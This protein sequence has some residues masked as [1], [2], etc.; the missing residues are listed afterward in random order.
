MPDMNKTAGAGKETTVGEVD[1]TGKTS[2]AGKAAGGLSGRFRKCVCLC[3]ALGMALAMGAC[4]YGVPQIEYEKLVS[5]NQALQSRVEELESRLSQPASSKPEAS[6][7][8]SREEPS[9]SEPAQS[10]RPA[11][12]DA[13][14]VQSQLK[15]TE[16]TWEKSGYY[17]VAFAVKNESGYEINLSA[18]LLLYDGEDS[19]IG[20][21]DLEEYAIPVGGE[22]L[23]TFSND[24]KFDHYTYE[25][26]PSECGNFYCV[27][28]DLEVTVN[29]AKGK[30]VVTV[31]NN[32]ELPAEFC[33]CTALF[34]SGGKPVGSYFTFCVDDDNE[35]KPGKSKS[36][37][38]RSYGSYDE[39]KVFVT[40]Q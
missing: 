10:A 29:K 1:K 32:G 21:K 39:V 31:K 2:K 15:V 4:S 11:A 16:Y 23:F 24:E 36:S 38:I 8:S 19:L 9:G 27:V 30:L 3:L 28:Q 7:S 18:N 25:L 13:K 12:F 40:A 35:I 22:I 5:E 26:Q 33:K 20:S 17:Y 37:E 14:A 6:S 34:F